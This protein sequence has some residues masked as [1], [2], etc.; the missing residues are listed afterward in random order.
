MTANKQL[1]ACSRH[2]A[3]HRGGKS[4]A[5]DCERVSGGY[6]RGLRYLS[7]EVIAKGRG[8]GYVGEVSRGQIFKKCYIFNVAMRPREEK[9]EGRKRRKSDK[10]P[11]TGWLQQQNLFSNDSREV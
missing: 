4:P 2:L 7:L 8:S 6:G 11:Q 5:G 3:G 10:R 1:N 9:K